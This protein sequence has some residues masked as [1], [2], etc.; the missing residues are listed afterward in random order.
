MYRYC[1]FVYVCV[2]IYT[3]ECICLERLEE[4][5]TSA[6]AGVTGNWGY[7]R[8]LGTELMFSVNTVSTLNHYAIVPAPNC[9][10][11]CSIILPL[12]NKFSLYFL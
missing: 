4:G 8:V 6:G 11:V 1:V 10:C 3:Y 7:R 9:F 12:D 5:V 2:C